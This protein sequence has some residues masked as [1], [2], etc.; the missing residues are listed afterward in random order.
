M[1]LWEVNHPYYSSESNFYSDEPGERFESWADYLDRW[2]SSD[3]DLNLLFRWD[4]IKP[5][6]SDYLSPADPEAAAYPQEVL[7]ETDTL[8]LFYI[9]QR[10][11]I[12][13]ANNVAVTEDD[14][15]SV[16]EFLMPRLAHLLLMWEPLTRANRQGDAGQS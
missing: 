7:P 1:R 8:W 2:G 13:L 11:G 3:L 14:E 12:Y 4:W 16:R 15:P 6:P 9:L 5:D 10:K